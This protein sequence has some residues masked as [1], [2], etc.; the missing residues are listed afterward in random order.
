MHVGDARRCTS[1]RSRADNDGI[2]RHLCRRV[3]D[4]QVGRVDYLV[5]RAQDQ[6]VAFMALLGKVLPLTVPNQP[7][8]VEE[9]TDDELESHIAAIA[10]YLSRRGVDPTSLEPPSGDPGGT[11]QTRH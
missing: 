3:A 7:K 4:C 2:R 8:P 6:P 10:Q 9:M 11:R 1:P 5:K